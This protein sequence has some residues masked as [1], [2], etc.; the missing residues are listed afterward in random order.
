MHQ[1]GILSIVVAVSGILQ[2][3][4][5]SEKVDKMVGRV[6]NSVFFVC[7]CAASKKSL[8]SVKLFNCG[9]EFLLC[10]RPGSLS[11]S[12]C[13]RIKGT[14]IIVQGLGP[15]FSLLGSTAGFT[16]SGLCDFD[17]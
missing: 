1:V 14:G 11:T 5:N 10:T 6:L 2:A 7:V 15:G 4:W 12:L 17:T 8:T 13:L 3:L 16:A 9:S